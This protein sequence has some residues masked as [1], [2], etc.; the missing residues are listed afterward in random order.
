MRLFLQPCV[1]ENIIRMTLSAATEIGSSA[2]VEIIL[3]DLH[4][5]KNI[6]V[7]APSTDNASN[8]THN[9]FMSCHPTRGFTAPATI[10]ALEKCIREV[11]APL[12]WERSLRA[13][14]LVGD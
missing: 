12:R 2:Q 5:L 1:C 10:T 4:I 11:C 3:C 7:R 6:L 8:N 9:F 13:E 14:R